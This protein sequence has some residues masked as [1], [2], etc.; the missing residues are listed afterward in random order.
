MIGRASR[1]K[2]VDLVYSEDGNIL[3]SLKSSKKQD[4]EAIEMTDM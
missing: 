4:D 3:L 1:E 2:R